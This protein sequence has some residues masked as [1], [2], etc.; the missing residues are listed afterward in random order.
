MRDSDDRFADHREIWER[1][2]WVVNGTASAEQAARVSDHVA[3]CGDCAAELQVQTRLRAAMGGEPAL[4]EQ[5]GAA[6]AKLAARLDAGPPRSAAVPTRSTNRR[7]GLLALAA[8]EALVI[9]ALG[10][11]LGARYV[12]SEA[13]V[14]RTLA[15]PATRPDAATIRAVF[16][17]GLRIEDL[18]A[19]LA[20]AHLRITEGPSTAGVFSL[21]PVRDGAAPADAAATD[22]ERLIAALRAHPGV[23][24]AEPAA[25]PA[26]PR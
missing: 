3:R 11:G 1:I 15:D 20:D 24:F 19:L 6:F 17:P 8:A 25:T 16:D 22:T 18:R 13:P 21:A 2:P 10:A 12:G 26:P 14:Y 4:D 5:A 9:V 7:P 23:R